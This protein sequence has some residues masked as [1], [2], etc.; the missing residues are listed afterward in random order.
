MRNVKD[1]T[2]RHVQRNS[3]LPA[4]EPPK[5]NHCWSVF[6]VCNEA[7]V[8]QS[9]RENDIHGVLE[10]SRTRGTLTQGAPV[11]LQQIKVFCVENSESTERE[12][13]RFQRSLSGSNKRS[14]SA[15]RVSVDFDVEC[16][17]KKKGED[18]IRCVTCLSVCTRKVDGRRLRKID[19]HVS[20]VC[21]NAASN[22]EKE[23]A[24][25]TLEMV[26]FPGR[27][28]FVVFHHA[29]RE[30]RIVVHGDDF[31]VQGK[32]ADLESI[33]AAVAGL[34]NG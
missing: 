5:K 20:M 9:S 1:C 26:G 23:F 19:L 14:P 6:T 2:L 30:V 28:I 4:N 7:N 15:R 12:V 10:L 25:N 27:A 34:S 3:L 16:W 32:K 31:V 13:V 18:K 21:A 24:T 29:K 22:S 8:S 33:A 11:P 17:N